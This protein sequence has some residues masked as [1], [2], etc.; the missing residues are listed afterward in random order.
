MLT[1]QN[2][3]MIDFHLSLTAYPEEIAVKNPEKRKEIEKYVIEQF[4]IK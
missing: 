2:K 3:S 1:E 4:K